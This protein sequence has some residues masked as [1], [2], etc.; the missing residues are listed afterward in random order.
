MKFQLEIDQIKQLCMKSDLNLFDLSWIDH[1][2]TNTEENVL[3][4]IK[5]ILF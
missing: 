5:F 1:L 2:M 3:K 4:Y